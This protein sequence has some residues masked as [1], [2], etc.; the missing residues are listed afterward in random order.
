MEVGCGAP[1]FRLKLHNFPPKRAHLPRLRL[2]LPIH[3]RRRRALVSR[4]RRTAGRRGVRG[5]LRDPPAVGQ[6]RRAE[7]PGRPNRHGGAALRPL[8]RRQ[9]A[10][11]AGASVRVRSPAPPPRSGTALRRRPF[12]VDTVLPPARRRRC[13]EARR[14]PAPRRLDRGL[15]ARL[16]AELSRRAQGDNRLG[17]PAAR[18]P[19]RRARILLLSAPRAQAAG[20][21]VPRADRRNRRLHGPARSAGARAGR[22]ARRVRGTAHSREG[23]ARPPAG[24]RS[25]AGNRARAARGDPRRRA[26]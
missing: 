7:H 3:R 14:L 11:R 22:A 21:G 17:D 19:R 24:A 16:L 6:G 2:S 10:H 25:R 20:R 15:D 1:A 8:C 9:A 23:G 18:D 13:S 12:G 5:H 26:V 4:A